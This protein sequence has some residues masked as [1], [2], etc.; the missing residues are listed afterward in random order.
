MPHPSSPHHKPRP[1]RQEGVEVTAKTLN[2]KSEDTSSSSALLLSVWLW[3]SHLNL[4]GLHFFSCK[5]KSLEQTYDFH[6]FFQS[7]EWWVYD[8][9]YESMG[10]CPGY[11]FTDSGLRNSWKRQGKAHPAKS[12]MVRAKRQDPLQSRVRLCMAQ[13]LSHSLTATSAAIDL[14]ALR[15]FSEELLTPG[16]LSALLQL[17]VKPRVRFSTIVGL[18]SQVTI[19]WK[20][21]K[22][23]WE[24]WG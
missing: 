9:N 24:G 14:T 8:F 22:S 5:I 13:G 20:R 15:C 17:H 6:G 7:Y 11:Y 2:W 23:V 16:L 3:A 10:L 18:C 19:L 12:E 4:T 1:D 21:G